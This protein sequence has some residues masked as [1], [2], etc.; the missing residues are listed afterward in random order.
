MDIE[1]ILDRE[2]LE[3]RLVKL[4]E[5]PYTGEISY[6]AMCYIP[7]ELSSASY[8]CTVCGYATAHKS[9]SHTLHRILL[10]RELVSELKSAGYDVLLDERY[11]CQYCCAERKKVYIGLTFMIRFSKKEKYHIVE[12]VSND[13]LRC[14]SAFLKGEDHFLDYFDATTPFY[15]WID[16]IGKMT[17]LGIS[18]V[19]KWKS[20]WK[21]DSDPRVAEYIRAKRTSIIGDKV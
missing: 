9:F 13:D 7:M 19:A 11:Y 6:G 12:D 5:T 2:A 15:D 4:A 17:G 3:E 18:T 10:A 14:V 8:E 20:T 16:W 1:Y 21:E